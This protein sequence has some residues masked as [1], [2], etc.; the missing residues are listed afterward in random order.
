MNFSALAAVVGMIA[1]VEGRIPQHQ[2]DVVDGD[3]EGRVAV[4]ADE[5]VIK[6]GKLSL[7]CHFVEADGECASEEHLVGTSRDTGKKFCCK[8]SCPTGGEAA[9]G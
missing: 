9:E 8:N 6:N 4:L 7:C 3:V 2:V 5:G 1:A